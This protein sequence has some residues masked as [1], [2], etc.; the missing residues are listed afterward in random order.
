MKNYQ[1]HVVQLIEGMEFSRESLILWKLCVVSFQSFII[2]SGKSSINR[3]I[4]LETN[5]ERGAAAEYSSRFSKSVLSRAWKELGK[6]SPIPF[7]LGSLVRILVLLK[8]SIGK[9]FQV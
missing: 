3:F 7:F 8:T 2:I 9:P 5:A 6:D 1:A 4:Y